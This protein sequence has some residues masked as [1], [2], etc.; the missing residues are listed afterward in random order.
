MKAPCRLLWRACGAPS[1][2][3]APLT[4]SNSTQVDSSADHRASASHGRTTLAVT[5][6]D[7]VVL[8]LWTKSTHAL[9]PASSSPTSAAWLMWCG[10]T[11][12]PERER[13]LAQI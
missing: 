8:T 13:F 9:A 6:A 12:A 11:S 10:Y 3:A 4:A 7:H 2:T 1:V 5:S